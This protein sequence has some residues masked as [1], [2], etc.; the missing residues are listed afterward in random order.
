MQITWT[1]LKYTKGCKP[2]ISFL[3][4][5]S[6]GDKD[7]VDSKNISSSYVDIVSKAMHGIA[8]IYC[9]KD[10]LDYEKQKPNCVFNWIN[11]FY[12][13]TCLGVKVGPMYS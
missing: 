7:K 3:V 13:S 1:K 12:E 5:I 9:S 6:S 11:E 8:S 4:L 10:V 2:H